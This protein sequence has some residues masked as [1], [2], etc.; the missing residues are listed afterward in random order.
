VC[1]GE[2]T[3][4]CLDT[5]DSHT[6][7]QHVLFFGHAVCIYHHPPLA[8][9]PHR[10]GVSSIQLI[11]TPH[12][13]HSSIQLN[14]KCVQKCWRSAWCARFASG[15]LQGLVSAGSVC[16][17]QGQQRLQFAGSSLARLPASKTTRLP[18]SKTS[19]ISTPVSLAYPRLRH[20]LLTLSPAGPRTCHVP[21]QKPRSSSSKALSGL[22]RGGRVRGLT[23]VHGLGVGAP[24]LGWYPAR[25]WC[26]RWRVP[27]LL[28]SMCCP[29]V[30]V[31]FR[32]PRS[33]VSMCRLRA[34]R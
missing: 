14:G 19:F 18:A 2:G 8:H 6:S 31:A 23:R 9:L 28:C 5:L 13:C 4:V 27:G 30:R 1:L 3:L 12:T 16:S 26:G 34:L 11:P 33:R 15:G 24:A 20:R 22:G 7:A 21:R 25:A 10:N 32:V 17:L 29:V